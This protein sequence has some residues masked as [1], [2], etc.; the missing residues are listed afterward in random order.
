MAEGRGRPGGGSP[1]AGRRLLL[2]LL[3]PGAL[4]SFLP[5]A[6]PHPSVTHRYENVKA[7]EISVQPTAV[8]EVISGGKD[9]VEVQ[10]PSNT[11]EIAAKQEEETLNDLVNLLQ[12]VVKNIP[13]ELV[14][15]TEHPPNFGTPEI[16]TSPSV[17]VDT[18]WVNVNPQNSEKSRTIALMKKDTPTTTA[19]WK[20]RNDVSAS[21]ILHSDASPSEDLPSETSESVILLSEEPSP[22]NT[23]STISV[24]LEKE[25]TT[26]KEGKSFDQL[27]NGALASLVESLRNVQ[28][29]HMPQ[30]NNKPQ[31]KSHPVTLAHHKPRGLDILE[32]ID[33]L[34]KTIKN[35]P[36]SVK[37]DPDLH[38]YVEEAEGYLKNA[39]ELS[40]EAERKL[41]QKK[42]QEMK[43]DIEL[44]NPPSTA[45]PITEMKLDIELP[46]SLSSEASAAEIKLDVE[47]T[48]SPST[49][50]P[51]T[52]VE[53]D[54]SP[55]PSTSPSASE[56]DIILPPS[57]SLEKKAED[58]EKEMGKLKAFINLLY[59]F[60]PELTEYAEN[61]PHKKMA[62]D[63]VERSMEVLDA[64]KSVFC[65]NPKKQSK[66]VLKHLLQKDMELVRQAMKE[67]KAS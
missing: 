32:A 37:E 35:A 3:L 1:V 54:I 43:P 42:E 45:P 55:S 21:V 4:L 41:L 52:R 48:P 62:Q 36:S 18:V 13:T 20:L 39:L 34:I 28:K 23:L 38:E 44:L 7:V 49:V 26:K 25:A 9:A 64:I 66:Q 53:I 16:V 60:S 30:G 10:Q 40:G 59:G 31:Q 29:L 22:G 8:E 6:T 65:G 61:S 56:V 46:P 50:P 11:G 12:D 14:M 51:V 63:I 5:Q 24:Q 33:T 19:F 47:V 58:T 17:A 67:K 15:S 27:T 57:E 2:L